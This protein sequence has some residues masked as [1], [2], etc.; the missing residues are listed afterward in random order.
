MEG[1][2]GRWKARGGNR[3]RREE[4]RDLYQFVFLENCTRTH[5]HAYTC[6]H[7]HTRRHTDV[8]F[9]MY[10]NAHTCTHSHAEMLMGHLSRFIQ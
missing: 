10:T 4:R 6:M 5:S 3:K 8:Q 7:M 9:H 1:R 2:E